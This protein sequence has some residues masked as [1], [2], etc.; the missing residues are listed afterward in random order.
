MKSTNKPVARSK[1][2]AQRRVN[3]VDSS[4]NRANSLQ[5]G[6][7][8]IDS[9]GGILRA[10]K[11]KRNGE[12]DME[13]QRGADW[14]SYGHVNLADKVAERKYVRL[15]RSIADYEKALMAGLAEDFASFNP[16]DVSSSA[17][18]ALTSGDAAAR[19]IR[20]Q[21]DEKSRELAIMSALLERKRD[22]LYSAMRTMRDKLEGAQR[23]VNV[24]ETYL[25]IDE[26]IV[27]IAEGQPAIVT[28]PLCF[29]QLVIHMDEEIGDESF[30]GFDFTKIEEFDQYMRTNY[31][32]LIPESKG[33]V[34]ARPRRNSKDYNA[35]DSDP[36]IGAMIRNE[37]MNEHNRKTYILIRNGENLYRIW[38][39]MVIYPHLFP[40]Q[41]EMQELHSS[42]RGSI[43]NQDKEAFI[44]AYKRNLILMQGLIDRTDILK[45]HAEGL[46]LWKVEEFKESV[47]FIYDGSSLL[48][49]GKLA[50]KDYLSKVNSEIKRGSRVYFG[51]FSHYDYKSDYWQWTRARFPTHSGTRSADGLPR[52]PK[53][54]FTVH[55]V[56][57]VDGYSEDGFL[58]R[59]KRKTRWDDRTFREVEVKRSTPFYLFRGDSCV[60]NYDSVSLEDVDFYLRDRVNRKSYL[61][62]MPI[63]KGIKA[64]RLKEL[65][66]DESFAQFMSGRFNRSDSEFMEKVWYA[67]DWWKMKV[68]NR[69]AL[70]SDDAKAV[71]MIHDKIQ[72]L[73]AD[74]EAK[75]D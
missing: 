13:T 43:R 3:D 37:M 34:V 30:G 58:L 21:L 12:W 68:I 23:I 62:M 44:L 32:T 14:V 50:W 26:D 59:F 19:A 5:P 15:E 41:D 9:D 17:E 52:P 42:D 7:L 48:P 38:T 46:N 1:S 65:Q 54:V 53:G 31:R 28:D 72:A 69:R 49:T 16:G 67:I 60:M 18:V 27:Q 74:V 57:P 56:N 73:L 47:K 51:G 11:R 4:A 66:V 63:L 70:Q 75:A 45:P 20:D 64:E 24:I 35:F 33:V 40:S 61:T 6:D 55:K 22:H 8:F 2:A 10:K 25:G 39:S 29:R 71:R 36:T